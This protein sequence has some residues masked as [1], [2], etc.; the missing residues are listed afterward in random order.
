MGPKLTME[1]YTSKGALDVDVSAIPAES[2]LC[3]FNLNKHS[4]PF[5]K[6]LS[7]VPTILVAAANNK[8]VGGSDGYDFEELRRRVIN[9]AFHT[10]VLVTPMDMEKY[11]DDAGFRIVRYMDNLTNLIYFVKKRTWLLLG[12]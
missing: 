4:S 8:I 7:M 1:V 2:I 5:S 12:K 9:N 6:I 3:N 10:S 11:F